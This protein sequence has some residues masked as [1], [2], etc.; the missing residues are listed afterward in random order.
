MGASVPSRMSRITQALIAGSAFGLKS[1]V[2][3]HSPLFYVEVDLPAGKRVL[4]PK[5]GP[6][7]GIY[8]ARGDIEVQGVSA[9]ECSMAVLG[10]GDDFEVI[11]ERGSKILLLGGDPM[12]G[13]RLIWWN[14]VP[15]PE[16]R[17]PQGV[18]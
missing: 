8:A 4:L 18:R 6:E 13:S 1:P 12:D 3:T 5:L 9:P 15:A 2:A 14:F 10:S 11:S 16:N 7:M 17:I